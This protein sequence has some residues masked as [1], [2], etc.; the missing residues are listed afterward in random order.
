MIK[1]RGSDSRM[2]G[3]FSRIEVV[4][5]EPVAARPTR[6]HLEQCRSLITRNRS[7][8]VP[9]DRSINPYRGCEHGCIYCFARPTHSYLDLSPGLDF[10]TELF[11]RVNAPAVLRAE[12]SRRSYRCA[13]VVLGTVTDP[14]QPVERETGL[15][16]AILQVLAEFRHPV[17]AI[18]KSALILRD[19]DLLAALAADGL[20]SV[21]VSVTTLDN[22]LKARLEP[23]ASS[24]ATR[25][26]VIRELSAAGVPVTV[27][28]APLIPF[29]ND[30]ELEDILAASAEAGAR[31]AGHVVLR[32]PH[33][34]APLWEEW[35][36][37][38]FP[39]RAER[40]MA[41]VREM[42][43]GARYRS[44]WF[45]RQTGRGPWATLLAQ[46]FRI[47][48]RKHGLDGSRG[49]IA[50]RTDLFRVPDDAPQLAL[51]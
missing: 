23:R 30:H 45:E 24:G 13:T 32:L 27:L 40:V 3:R 18:T 28:V 39:R 38:H 8:D 14:W 48:A 29:I 6:L 50:L 9:F 33:E 5:E 42:H 25:L 43:G 49:R 51:F 46:R 10:E 17:S 31:G 1:G 4:H 22:G 20:A 16:R 41:V 12:L 2:A 47:A 34:V 21:A 19:L 7:P 15:T 37:E 44:E 36:G 11:A 26:K 35:L